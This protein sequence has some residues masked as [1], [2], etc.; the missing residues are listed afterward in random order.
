[1]TSIAAD[2][3]RQTL[4]QLDR[5]IHL[6]GLPLAVVKALTAHRADVQ[7]ALHSPE[8]TA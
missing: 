6:P 1:M 8:V 2:Y 7:D 5:T 3:C 4:I